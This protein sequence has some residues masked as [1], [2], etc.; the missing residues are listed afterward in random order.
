MAQLAADSLLLYGRASE[1][2]TK[3]LSFDLSWDNFYVSCSWQ[4]EKNNHNSWQPHSPRQKHTY[5]PQSI[6]LETSAFQIS[7][8]TSM[9]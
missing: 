8:V 4:D 5:K 3:D 2:R 1:R 9:M 7:Q 6:E